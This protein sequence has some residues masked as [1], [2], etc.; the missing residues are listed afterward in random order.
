MSSTATATAE[1]RNW[2][3]LP[4]EVTAKILMKLSVVEIIDRAQK[5]CVSW[6]RIC[7]DPSMWRHIDMSNL[8]DLDANYNL[9]KLCFHV[10]DRCQGNLID[11]SIDYFASYDILRYIAER[12]TGLKRLRLYACTDLSGSHEGMI[13]VVLK[14]PLLEELEATLCYFSV[15]ALKVIGKSCP[16]LRCLKWNKVVRRVCRFDYSGCNEEALTIAETMPGLRHLQLVGNDMTDDGLQ[17][18]LKACPHLES[19]DLRDCVHLTNVKKMCADK[20]NSL[21]LPHAH[22]DGYPSYPTY[23]VYPVFDEYTCE[24]SDFESLDEDDDVE[25][26]DYDYPGDDDGLSDDDIYDVL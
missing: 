12:T 21:T 1:N 19:L 7:K 13:E 4:D 15:E 17:A 22:T 11:I 20:I 6:R 26:D 10:I 9:K 25:Y 5:V 16:L 18:I 24:F 3:D 2:L 14:F 23:P 8:D